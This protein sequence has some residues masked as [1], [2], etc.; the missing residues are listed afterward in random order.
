MCKVVNVLSLMMTLIVCKNVQSS[1]DY[2]NREFNLKIS[3]P[4][5]I[6]NKYPHPQ[7]MVEE[8]Q[9][10]ICYINGRKINKL[11]H[12]VKINSSKT[13]VGY[14]AKTST[15][16]SD[17]AQNENIIRTPVIC[18]VTLIKTNRTCKLHFDIAESKYHLFNM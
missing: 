17:M 5:S 3:Y 14:V 16:Y 2:D 13:D 8:R 6:L 4:S 18:S 10:I 9:E 15:F 1:R 7:N 11:H 12:F